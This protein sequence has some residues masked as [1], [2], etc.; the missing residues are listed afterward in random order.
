[1]KAAGPTISFA[2]DTLNRVCTK[3]I[4]TTATACSATS[5][6]SPTVWFGYDLNGRATSMTDNSA[7]ITA[8]VLPVPGT[9]VSYATTTSYDRL[10]RPVNVSFSPAPA[11]T[12]PAAGSV[13]FAHAYNAVNQRVSQT[14]TDNGWWFYPPAV[15]STVNYTSNAA[16]QYTAVGAVSPSYNSN[17]N[18]TFDGAFV[19]G[20]DA[21]NRLTSRVAQQLSETNPR[22]L[23][24]VWFSAW[25]LTR[26]ASDDARRPRKERGEVKSPPPPARTA[27]TAPGRAR[28][29]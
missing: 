28:A 12:A 21:E 7:A 9:P 1:V 18:L 16:N 22:I 20:Y 29:H 8:A 15:A 4:S 6:A 14:V 24:R 11:S 26:L 19:Y 23:L 17:G 10:N 27:R 13:T 25:P 5:S 3:T 2:Y